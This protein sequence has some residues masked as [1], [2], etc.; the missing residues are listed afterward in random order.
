MAP[1]DKVFERMPEYKETVMTEKTV[2][3]D[4]HR[5]MAAQKATD[6]RRLPSDVEADERSSRLR[7]DELE[8]HLIA[9][10]AANWQEAAEKER[11]LLNL[12]L[13]RWRRRIRGDTSSSQPC[14]P[15]SSCCPA[16]SEMGHGA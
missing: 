7:Q 16:N 12:F 6:L 11:Y 2:D 9:A 10:P 4:H 13:L 8:S 15:I 1:S 3:L 14:W 5:G